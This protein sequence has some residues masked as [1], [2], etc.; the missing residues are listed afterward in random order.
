MRSPSPAPTPCASPTACSPST[1]PTRT[2][3][4]SSSSSASGGARPRRVRIMTPPASPVLVTGATGN[5]GQAVV[6]ALARRGV[7]VRAMVRA[8]ADRGKL[9]AALRWPSPTSTIRH[10]SPRRCGA[11]D[12]R[13]WSRRPPSTPRRSSGASPT[14][15]P[16][17]RRSPRRALPASRR[18][19]LASTVPALSRRGRAARPRPGHRLHLPAAQPVLPGTARPGQPIAADG[20]FFAPIGDAGQRG[21]RAGHRR[22]P[23]LR[24]R[25][26]HHLYR[27]TT[28]AF[29]ESLHGILPPW[30]IQGLL[31]DYAHYRRGEAASVSPRSP[32]SPAGPQPTSC[33]SARDCAQAFAA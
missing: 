10:P 5:T 26:R 29:A 7:P 27:R 17:R 28:Q 15:P 20:R 24:P 22:G 2:A 18:P 11:P 21:G 19:A 8:E 30:Q 33:F 4:C 14:W 13:T 31:E 6:Q 16:G 1:G 23:D 12:G 3:C 25:P 9:P 32:R